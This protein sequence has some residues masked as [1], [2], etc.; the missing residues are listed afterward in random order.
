M[1]TFNKT[2]SNLRIQS[3]D[4]AKKFTPT[5]TV[6]DLIKNSEKVFEYI[7]PTVNEESSKSESTE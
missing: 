6:D 3:L 4:M 5:G 1:S 2:L 7:F